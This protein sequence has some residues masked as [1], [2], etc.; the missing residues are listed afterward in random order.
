MPSLE[1]YLAHLARQL[2]VDTPTK[3]K[4]VQEIRS[5]LVESAGEFHERGHSPEESMALAIAR[6]GEAKEVAKMMR[7]VYAESAPLSWGKIGLAI[8]P[9]L[10]AFAASWDV[11]ARGLIPITGLGLCVLLV[12]AG[13]IRERKFPVWGFTT[14]GVLF[15]LLLGWLWLPLGLLGLLAPIIILPWYKRSGVHVSGLAWVLVGLMI[16]IGV[17]SPAVLSIFP[18]YFFNWNLWDLAGDI[19]MLLVVAVGLLLAKRSGLVA[20]LF[21]VAAGFILWEEVLDLTYGL[22][23]TPWGMVMIAILALLLLVVSPIWVLRSHSTRGQVLGLLLPALIA[24][25]SVVTINAI[26]RTAPFIL[27]RIVNVSPMVPATPKPWIGVGVRGR[28]NLVPI[29]IKWGMTAAQMFMGLMLAVVLYLG[30]ERQGPAMA[31]VHKEMEALAESPKTTAQ[32]MAVKG[33]GTSQ[34]T[35]AGGN[36]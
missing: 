19:V 23:K 25:A 9:G 3:E 15:G 33:F 24:L 12:V 7:Q 30:V 16:A 27:D 31:S 18:G 22:W 32:S 10:F 35:V 2:Y 1:E 26:V 13:L 4:I 5:H 20:G 17:S 14:L 34:T 11:N 21:V 8:L 29:L 6:F 36:L 28:E